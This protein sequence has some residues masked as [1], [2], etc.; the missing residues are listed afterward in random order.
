MRKN[1]S[2]Y[3]TRTE[4]KDIQ[5]LVNHVR[6][7]DLNEIEWALL[8]DPDPL[9]E[10]SRVELIREKYSDIHPDILK[11]L[12][13]G[14][15]ETIHNAAQEALDKIKAVKTQRY[16]LVACKDDKEREEMV[17]EIVQSRTG[18]LV[19]E[20]KLY[21]QYEGR[22]VS[23]TEY[24]EVTVDQAKKLISVM[25]MRQLLRN[26]EVTEEQIWKNIDHDFDAGLDQK[27]Q[28]LNDGYYDEFYDLAKNTF[29]DEIT[30]KIRKK[31]EFFNDSFCDALE[32]E[33]LKPQ[34]KNPFHVIAISEFQ[35]DTLLDSLKQ[36]GFFIDNAVN[37]YEGEE[38][39]Y[40]TI[41]RIDPRQ[42][43]VDYQPASKLLEDSENNVM[44]VNRYFVQENISYDIDLT[45]IDLKQIEAEFNERIQGYIDEKLENDVR[46]KPP[47]H[48]NSSI[49]MTRQE[50]LD[51]K[52]R[53]VLK[54][55]SVFR[56]FL[57]SQGTSYDR[58]SEDLEA[59]GESEMTEEPMAIGI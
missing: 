43:I 51:L 14:K 30:D 4:E 47:E 54:C 20:G 25:E 12:A 13:L 6:R 31:T 50:V 2:L 40:G 27:L 8:E 33:V 28:S 5:E 52:N 49:C 39:P 32:Y 45:G 55:T 48:L 37:S 59:A 23:D 46:I 41:Y 19:K 56:E 17:Q 10:E 24:P 16:C 36:H 11:L 15:S 26:S 38:D 53:S 9:S 44:S 34:L 18:L 3:E 22:F 58:L 1:E 42:K 21:L 29:G 57:D 35:K 7:L